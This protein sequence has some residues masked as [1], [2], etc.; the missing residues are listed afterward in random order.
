MF[1][2]FFEFLIPIQGFDGC[3]L[4]SSFS[5]FFLSILFMFH[6]GFSFY[7]NEICLVCK[8]CEWFSFC[9]WWEVGFQVVVHFLFWCLSVD[10]FVHW[11]SMLWFLFGFICLLASRW[12]A[13]IMCLHISF[14]LFAK[15]YVLM[16][17]SMRF[18]RVQK[19]DM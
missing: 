6:W 9:F 17:W 14:C 13:I 5:F 19:M 7:V 18:D 3:G 15:F 12:E 4:S 10:S 16:V 11:K 1:F 8:C 2:F